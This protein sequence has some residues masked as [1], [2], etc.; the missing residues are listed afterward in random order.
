MK[1]T[2]SAPIQFRL[3]LSDYDRLETLASEQ[4]VTPKDYVVNLTLNHIHKPPRK[5]P[6]IRKSGS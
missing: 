6:A 4:G 5:Q 1:R 2:K 3:L